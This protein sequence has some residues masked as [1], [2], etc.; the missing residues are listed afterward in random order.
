MFG[1]LLAE[2]AAKQAELREA[3]GACAQPT[4]LSP[5][6]TSP[7]SERARRAAAAALATVTEELAGAVNDGVAEV[8][9][10]QRLIE[11]EARELQAQA[12]AFQK[13]TGKWVALVTEFDKSLREVGDFENWVRCMEWDM[14]A[15]AQ[16]LEEA[17]KAGD[18]PRR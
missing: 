8:F 18:A 15:V 10:S 7:R 13:Q 14:Q 5:L 9:N 11:A 16:A 3:N 12:V 17:A 2:H 6:L 4:A 1:V